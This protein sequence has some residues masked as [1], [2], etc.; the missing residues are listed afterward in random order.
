MTD[1]E[2]INK[3]YWNGAG[4]CVGR[5]KAIDNYSTVEGLAKQ[6]TRPL[7]FFWRTPEGKLE[8]LKYDN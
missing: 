4:H 3:K 8:L 7:I 5:K 2:G 1:I 6:T